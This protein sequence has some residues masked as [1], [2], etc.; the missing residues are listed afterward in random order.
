MNL[1]YYAL[2]VPQELLEYT[3]KKSV[4]LFRFH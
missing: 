4:A 2:I 1:N 3:H